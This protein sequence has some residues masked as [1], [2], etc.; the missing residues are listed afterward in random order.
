M[1]K[2][3]ENTMTKA[4]TR[5]VPPQLKVAI[6]TPSQ[7]KESSPQTSMVSNLAYIPC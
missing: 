2:N 7:P 5:S 1:R 3:G 4:T 6:C